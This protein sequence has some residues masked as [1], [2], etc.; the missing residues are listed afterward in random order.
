MHFNKDV[1]QQNIAKYGGS[2]TPAHEESVL[3]F[4]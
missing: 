3:D 1:I 4:L 2:G